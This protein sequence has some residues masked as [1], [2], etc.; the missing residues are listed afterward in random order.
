MEG[1]A[2]EDVEAD[3]KDDVEDDMKGDVEDGVEGDIEAV[4]EGDHRISYYSCLFYSAEALARWSAERI[5]KFGV[6]KQCQI[7]FIK[8][9]FILVFI[10][11]DRKWCI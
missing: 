6:P 10:L 5:N 9:V 7:L 11:V 2:K 3:D 8:L 1:D 4:V